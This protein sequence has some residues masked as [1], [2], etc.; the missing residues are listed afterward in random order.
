MIPGFVMCPYL[1]NKIIR[2]KNPAEKYP[3][4]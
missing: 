3:D 1:K 2:G 4:N